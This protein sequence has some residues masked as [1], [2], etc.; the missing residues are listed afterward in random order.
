VVRIEG[1]EHSDLNFQVKITDGFK[2]VAEYQVGRID[3]LE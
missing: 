3:K 1:L 2:T